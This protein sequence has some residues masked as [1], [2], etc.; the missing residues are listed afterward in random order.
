MTLKI[1]IKNKLFSYKKICFFI[2]LFLLAIPLSFAQK[3]N[4][5]LKIEIVAS[6]NGKPIEKGQWYVTKTED[7]I[8]LSKLKLYLTNFVIQTKAKKKDSIKNSN[9]LIDV[10]KEETL[11]I[12]LSDVNYNAEDVLIFNI[13]VDESLNTSGANSGDLDP[14]KGMFWSWQSGYINFKIE[15]V[16]PS[17]KTRKNKFQFHIG[18]YQKPYETIQAVVFKLDILKNSRLKIN[19]DVSQFFKSIKLSSKNQIMIPGE[20]ASNTADRLPQL[21]SI[22]E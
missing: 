6:F 2:F 17:C 5:E 22:H 4:K 3:R 8:Q 9:Y 1:D 20:E 10:F 18:G 14:A 11:L 13:G 21:F 12:T 15:G 16:S 7:S 19:L